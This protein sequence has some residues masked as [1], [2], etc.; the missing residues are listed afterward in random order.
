[1]PVKKVEVRQDLGDS[2]VIGSPLTEEDLKDIIRVSVPDVD[3]WQG[4]FKQKFMQKGITHIMLWPHDDG[5]LDKPF[6]F[7]LIKLTELNTIQIR[8]KKE[9]L[10]N[11]L[12]T[13]NPEFSLDNNVY[14]QTKFIVL[15]ETPFR[16][17]K[18]FFLMVDLAGQDRAKYING[19]P[20]Q[21]GDIVSQLFGKTNTIPQQSGPV[22]TSVGQSNNPYRPPHMPYMPYMPF[23]GPNPQQT[24]TYS[25]HGVTINIYTNK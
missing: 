3:T 19:E 25:G 9:K 11:G 12:D 2:V 23:M 14:P 17:Y 22:I 5:V 24:Q 7:R 21:K 18:K 13:L 8:L 15:R 20:V 4:N 1:M 6:D 10:S 16:C